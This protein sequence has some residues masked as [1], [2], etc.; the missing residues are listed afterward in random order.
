VTARNQ[1]FVDGI[2]LDAW[3]RG[4]RLFWC[5]VNK[6]DEYEVEQHYG[7]SGITVWKENMNWSAWLQEYQTVQQKPKTANASR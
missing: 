6:D 5:P 4:G 7:H 2:L 3:R 1:P